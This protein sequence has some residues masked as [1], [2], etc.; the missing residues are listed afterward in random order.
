MRRGWARKDER[1]RGGVWVG[2]SEEMARLE[3]GQVII[4]GWPGHCP[5]SNSSS[6]LGID[7]FGDVDLQTLDSRAGDRV[8][9]AR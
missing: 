9:G 7:W 2:G 1:V 6:G 4:R 5:G 3:A 8:H